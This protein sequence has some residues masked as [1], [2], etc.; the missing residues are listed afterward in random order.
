MR[1]AK[2]S[3]FFADKHADAWRP[4]L[5]E[6]IAGRFMAQAADA[7]KPEGHVIVKEPASQVADLLLSLF[8][9]SRL[10]FLLRDGRDVVDSWL[11]GYED[12]AWAQEEGAFPLAH[13]GREAFIRWQSSVWAY[14]VD[15]VGRAYARHD[16]ERCVLVR[17]ED[18]LDDTAPHLARICA[19]TGLPG[20][21]DRIE[22]V[23]SQ[24]GIRAVPDSDR[25]PTRRIRS[26]RPGGWRHSM[27]AAEQ[28][29]ML[30]EMGETLMRFGYSEPEQLG[31][32]GAGRLRSAA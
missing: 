15:A 31:L 6:L 4:L 19:V 12:G 27:S 5:R 24:Y 28:Q 7:G 20:S 23:A 21:P 22:A 26:A 29:A 10:I 1:R 18:L 9:S 8:P 16:P 30:E 25:G 3:Y 14:R 17:Y 2:P 32:V 13:D 11:A